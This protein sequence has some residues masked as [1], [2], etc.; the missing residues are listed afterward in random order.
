MNINLLMQFS[1]LIFLLGIICK[2]SSLQVI[3]LTW[4]FD[5]QTIFWSKS[6]QRF[7]YTKQVAEERNGYWYSVNDFCSGEHVGTHFDA[8]YHFYE[9]GWKIGDVPPHRLIAKGAFI[10]LQD[11]TAKLGQ[12]TMLEVAD[13]ERWEKEHGSFENETVLLV[14]FGWSKYW[15]N[16]T[17]YMGLEGD[18]FNFPGISEEAAEYL[19]NSGKFYG[20]GVD[21]ASVDP[22]SSTTFRAHVIFSKNQM[23]NLE[24]VK[25]TETLPAKGFTL[26]AL[27]MKLKDGTGASVRILALPDQKL[28]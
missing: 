11:K 4:P 5:N 3:D 7:S 2:C 15:Y 20:I 25:I 26:L 6:Q 18:S 14:K 28:W 13:L 8:P 24:N 12:A 21:T 22:G 9:T 16:R 27:P 17:L 19:V 10:D 23:Y 1:S